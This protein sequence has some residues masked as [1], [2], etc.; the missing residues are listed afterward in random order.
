MRGKR[1]KRGA[2]VI[3]AAVLTA[4]MLVADSRYHLQTTEYELSF[5]SLPEEFDGFR[6]VHLSDLHGM[7]F[8]KDNIRLARRVKEL[9]PDLIALTG[10]F[11]EYSRD[12][13][14]AGSLL[15]ELEGT[16]PLYWVN[17]N[18][19]WNN[20][21][22]EKA[23]QELVKSCGGTCLNDKFEPLYRGTGRIIIAGSD[24]PNTWHGHKTP[25]ELAGE[26]REIY[27]EDFVLW[28]GH[29][30]F[31]TK[32]YPGLPVELILSGHA[33]GGIIRIPGVGGLL[34]VDRSFGATYEAGLYSGERFIMEVSR[35]LGNSIPVPRLFNRPEIA[36][37]TL[38]CKE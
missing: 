35:G 17:G 21:G 5:S 26:L 3:V 33:H 18:H 10:D 4:A 23:M 22:T 29:R 7:S 25:E 28:L 36:V 9:E 19:E 15:R 27:P 34:N 20:G 30:N 32:D 8:G 1:G 6:I 24:D 16:A 11:T 31:W 38:K 13:P 12:L 37:I 14:A 2:A